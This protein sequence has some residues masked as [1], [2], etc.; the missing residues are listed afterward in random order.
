MF[1]L[2]DEGGFIG[3]SDFQNTWWVED[4]ASLIAPATG[5]YVELEFHDV[6]TF[7]VSA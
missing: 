3:Q 4:T 5:F 6:A 7:L 2:T 1:V